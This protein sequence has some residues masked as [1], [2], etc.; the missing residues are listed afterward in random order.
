MY[1]LI[2]TAEAVGFPIRIFVDQSI[3]SAPHN[4][5]QTYTSFI[6]SNCLGIHRIRLVT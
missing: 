1:S 6:A 2:D 3:L 5:S 4:F